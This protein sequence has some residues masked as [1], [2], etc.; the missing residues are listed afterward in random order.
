MIVVV[1]VRLPLAELD[2]GVALGLPA[3]TEVAFDRMVPRGRAEAVPFVWVRTDDFEAFERVATD[4]PRVNEVEALG[5]TDGRRLYR[6]DW[7]PREELC[8]AVAR[9]DAAILE[10]SVDGE[11][12]RL[13]LRFPDDE[14]VTRFGKL[15][16]ESGLSMTPVRISR[17]MEERRT[18]GLTEE[19]RETL[20]TAFR[21]GYF[22]VPRRATL[23]DIADEL[24]VSDQAVSERIRRGVGR[25]VEASVVS[26]DRGRDY[27]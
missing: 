17:R 5:E 13:Q 12:L 9:T 1:D 14:S 21:L 24:D 2:A 11:S 6:V 26:A 4:Q 3:D 23:L 19:Q 15:C 22:D 25:L 20:L 18:A 7:T 16:A 27:G 10:G 8:D